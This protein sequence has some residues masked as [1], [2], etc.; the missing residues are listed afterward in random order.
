MAKG[1]QSGLAFFVEGPMREKRSL[2]P[3]LGGDASG[4]GWISGRSV[5]TLVTRQGQPKHLREQNVRAE[6]GGKKAS[7][8]ELYRSF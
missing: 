6:K 1:G 3:L 8:F 5:T 7:R 4:G 2:P